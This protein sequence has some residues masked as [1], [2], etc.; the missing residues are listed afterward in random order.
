MRSTHHD[1]NDFIVFGE[2]ERAS[3]VKARK[4]LPHTD[5]KPSTDDLMALLAGL[6]DDSGSDDGFD[7]SVGDEG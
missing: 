4:A 1:E 3:G 5:G 2:Y 7:P 6:S